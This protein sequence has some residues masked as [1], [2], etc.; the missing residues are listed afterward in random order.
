[1]A[2]ELGFAEEDDDSKWTLKNDEWC[3]EWREAKGVGLQSKAREEIGRMEKPM[4][5]TEMKIICR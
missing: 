1:M 3:E 5:E 4:R 2:K